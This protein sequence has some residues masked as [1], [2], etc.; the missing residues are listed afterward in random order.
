MSQETLIVHLFLISKSNVVSLEIGLHPFE[1]ALILRGGPFPFTDYNPT[2][3]PNLKPFFSLFVEELVS[4]NSSE[5]SNSPPPSPPAID[6]YG[7]TFKGGEE[8]CLDNLGMESSYA[9]K[10]NQS[11]SK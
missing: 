7:S 1:C 10:K 8:K 2:H 11:T 9:T 4:D 3:L 6:Q 5:N